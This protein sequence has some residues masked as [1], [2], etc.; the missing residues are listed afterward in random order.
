MVQVT[1]SD[2]GGGI[3]PEDLP[4][5]FRRFYRAKGACKA[6]GAGVGAVHYP[7]AGRGSRWRNLGGEQAK[8]GQQLQLPLP[9]SDT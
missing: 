9:I 4:Y 1:V 3:A 5:L 8:K 6:E 7:D 2:Q